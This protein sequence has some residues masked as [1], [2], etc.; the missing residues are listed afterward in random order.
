MMLKVAVCHPV[1][2][3]VTRQRYP[4]ELF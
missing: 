4:L 2:G 3:S 1:S